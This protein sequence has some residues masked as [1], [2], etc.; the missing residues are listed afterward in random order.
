V[1]GGIAYWF[2]ILTASGQLQVSSS[3]LWEREPKYLSWYNDQFAGWM[4]EES[5]FD[6]HQKHETFPFLI[7][8]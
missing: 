7:T 8:L 2:L 6:S 3:Y 5:R 1:S 4:T